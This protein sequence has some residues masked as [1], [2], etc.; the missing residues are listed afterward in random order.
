MAELVKPTIRGI[1]RSSVWGMEAFDK[2]LGH[3]TETIGVFIDDLPENKRETAIEAIS[4]RLQLSKRQLEN[5]QAGMA[6]EIH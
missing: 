4:E 5:S 1:S 6:E 3:A 2:M